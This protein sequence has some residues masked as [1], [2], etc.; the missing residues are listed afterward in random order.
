M[1]VSRKQTR[2]AA[3]LMASLLLV[4]AG[5]QPASARND[6][7]PG[8]SNARMAQ[9][10]EAD[11][12]REAVAAWRVA[13]KSYKLAVSTRERAVKA[14]NDAFAKS[15]QRARA[16]F[17]AAMAR[18][19]SPSDE[20]RAQSALRAAIALAAATRQAALDALIPLPPTPGSKPTAK[21]LRS[22]S[23]SPTPVA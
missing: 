16:E 7:N 8:Q 15:V 13:V 12:L 23:A 1:P 22:P 4:G 9:A 21:S 6:P 5:V 2:G 17:K 19:V 14:I 20:A 3:V 11:M 10:L 18:A